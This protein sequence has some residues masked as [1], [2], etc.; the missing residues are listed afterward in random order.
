MITPKTIAQFLSGN[1]AAIG[2]VASANASLWLAFLFIVSAGLARNYD[3]HLLLKEPLWLGGPVIMSLFSSLFIYGFVKLIGGLN[4]K[5][6][7]SQNYLSFLRCFVMTAPLAWLYGIPVERFTDPLPA[8]IFN[9]TVLLIVSFWRVALMTRV[10]QVLFNFHPI[11]A[12][13]LIAIPASVEMF[14]A[15]LFKSVDIVGIMGGMRLSEADKFLLAATNTMTMGSL[16][17]FVISILLIF[18]TPRRDVKSWQPSESRIKVGKSSWSFAIIIIALWLGIAIEPQKKL[19]KL[20]T[21]RSLVR[22][23]NYEEASHFVTVTTEEE[24]PP[25]RRLLPKPSIYSPPPAV[26]LLAFWNDWPAWFRERLR[27]DVSDW[28][29]GPENRSQ[30][31]QRKYDTL[32]RNL[33]EA[34]FVQE[35]ADE[36][37][38]GVSP[39]THFRND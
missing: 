21:F 28:L 33:N 4:R 7:T 35:F 23:E 9:F 12:F 34:P 10:L 17:I 32:Y 5:K 3:H 26:R 1:R 30:N 14:F 20:E 19:R 15:T 31:L 37:T 25:H 11:R 27:E 2:K 38:P 36:F 18:Y 29:I 8:T 6:C 24:F 39:E 16:I 22:H 13:V